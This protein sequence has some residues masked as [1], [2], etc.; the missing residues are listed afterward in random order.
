M[1]DI[2]A[3]TRE[4]L[5]KHSDWEQPQSDRKTKRD[6]HR[7]ISVVEGM[8]RRGWISDEQKGAFD[9]FSRHIEKA[10]RVHL[11]MC[12]YG[13]PFIG[14]AES[15]WDPIDIRNAAVL[16]VREACAAVGVPNEVRALALAALTETTLEA[17]GREI[18]GTANQGRAITAG[19]TLLQSGTYRLA[20]HYGFIRGP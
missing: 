17:I 7:I 8:H 11:P 19:K 6:H 9:K 14:S 12:Q 15:D 3:P 5:A 20:L 1:T 10:E 2:L 13:R 16:S 18:D 4:R